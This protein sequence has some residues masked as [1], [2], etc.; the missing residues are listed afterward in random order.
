MFIHSRASALAQAKR[1]VHM[2]G[3]LPK[4]A[5]LTPVYNGGHL[6]HRAMDSVQAQTYPNVHHI[7]QDNACTDST[8]EVVAR[9]LN[10]AKPVTVYRNPALVSSN[11]NFNAVMANRPADADY[12]M[13]L[14]ADDVLQPNVI[15]AMV[16]VAESD[17]GV[18]AVTGQSL[19]VGKILDHGWPEASPVLDGAEATRL[20]LRG[21]AG[22]TGL[23]VLF[24]ANAITDVP[25]FRNDMNSIDLDAALRQMLK[26]K[27]AYLKQPVAEMVLHDASLS[28][29]RLDREYLHFQDFLTLMDHYG[30]QVMDPASFAATRRA[31]LR[32]YVRRLV[33]WRVAYGKKEIVQ[34]HLNTAQARGK[35]FT[36]YDLMDALVDFGLCKVGLRQ[37]WRTTDARQHN[38][39]E[40]IPPPDVVQR[41]AERAQKLSVARP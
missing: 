7:V 5:V 2:S 32:H 41:R 14:C 13:I 17:P 19:C 9:Y 36:A 27:F 37:Q 18:M 35:P 1:I 21:E 28:S 38:L 20:L 33:F 11:K 10:C 24:R 30:P 16:A 15:E 25:F 4:V 31:Y 34:R 29:T 26:G 23:F 3:G 22:L 8:P 12:V 40:P 39:F 6:I